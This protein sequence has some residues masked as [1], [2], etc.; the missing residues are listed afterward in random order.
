MTDTTADPRLRI[1]R[2]R[3]YLTACRVLGS[4]A[5]LALLFRGVLAANGQ[6]NSTS[7]AVC[8]LILVANPLVQFW[9]YRQT[10]E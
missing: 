1:I 7:Q 3:G 4:F 8:W 10:R 9:L 6:W 2:Y 5:L